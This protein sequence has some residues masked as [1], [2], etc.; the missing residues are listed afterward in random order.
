M[1]KAHQDTP[2]GQNHLGTLVVALPSPFEGGEFI[3][4]KSGEEATFDWST[5]GRKDH[6]HDLHW[7]F[8]YADIEHEILPVKTGYRV[9]VSYHIFGS[10]E[11]EPGPFTRGSESDD[12]RTDVLPTGNLNLQYKLTPLFSTL[13]SS[14]KD[15]KFLPKGGRLA[16]GLDHEYGVAGKSNV[17]FLNDYYKGKDAVFVSTLKA[18]G[19]SFQFKAV[20]RVDADGYSDSEPDDFATALQGELLLLWD[21]FAGL[22]LDYDQSVAPQFVEQGAKADHSLVWVNRPPK[23]GE[24]CTYAS[25]GNEP[26][27][28]T[29]YVAAALIV[30]IPAFGT[31]RRNGSFP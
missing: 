25:Y 28:K 26:S 12:L 29:L 14:Y 16:F 31:T 30:D 10:R 8:F 1:F 3:L 5:S 20:Y 15:P 6:P 21:H 13:I 19:L 27:V 17:K 18:M 11:T 9:T 7:I 24:A 4:R 22:Y 23:Y 2:R